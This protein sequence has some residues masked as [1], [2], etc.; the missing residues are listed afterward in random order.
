MINNLAT[1]DA[2]L[3]EQDPELQEFTPEECERE[4][5][6]VLGYDPEMGIEP[7]AWE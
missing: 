5:W 1:N 2:I 4:Y 6:R 7:D 3:A